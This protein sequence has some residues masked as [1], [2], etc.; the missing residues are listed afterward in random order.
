MKFHRILIPVDGS[1]TSNKAL[2]AALQIAR[3]AG[4][5]VRLVHQVDVLSYLTGFEASAVVLEEIRKGTRRVVSAA[6]EIANAAGVPTETS[7]ID[8][9]GETLGDAVAREAR[10]WKADL[11]VIGTHGRRGVQRLL[12]GSGAEQ[13]IRLA[14]VPVLVIR[15]DD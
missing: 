13:V 1:P 7:I 10:E 8:Q 5:R 4:G 11:V 3:D 2:V 6:F 14:P 12:L 9:P 15:A